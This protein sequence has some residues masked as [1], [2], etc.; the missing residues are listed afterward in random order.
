ML[1]L[2]TF[3]S[4]H[5]EKTALIRNMRRNMESVKTAKIFDTPL[6]RDWIEQTKSQHCNEAHICFIDCTPRNISLAHSHG[7]IVMGWFPHPVN[8]SIWCK[9]TEDSALYEFVA[10]SGVDIMCVNKPGL[11]KRVLDDMASL[12][13]SV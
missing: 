10:R 3:S 12:A 13:K 11:L 4:F 5:N 6:T 2:V 9:Y 7:I 1:P 8:E